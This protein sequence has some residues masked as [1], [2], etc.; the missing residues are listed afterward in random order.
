MPPLSA[1]ARDLLRA[2]MSL[3]MHACVC[4]HAFVV[5]IKMYYTKEKVLL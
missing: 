4:H 5:S 1:V 3:L 2:F